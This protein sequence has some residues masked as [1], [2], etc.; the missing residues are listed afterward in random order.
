[1]SKIQ[2]LKRLVINYWNLRFICDLVLGIWDLLSHELSDA[3]GLEFNLT[4]P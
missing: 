3:T 1:M 2:N 4:S